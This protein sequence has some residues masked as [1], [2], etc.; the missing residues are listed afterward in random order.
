MIWDLAAPHTIHVTRYVGHLRSTHLR[1][2]LKEMDGTV[3]E[4]FL[5]DTPLNM[6]KIFDY[7]KSDLPHNIIFDEAHKHVDFGRATKLS[8]KIRKICE[9]LV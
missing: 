2:T 7:N 1:L 9:H 6:A 5:T 3:A 4:V 8:T